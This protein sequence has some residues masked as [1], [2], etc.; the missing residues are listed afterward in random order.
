MIRDL[1][2]PDR[3][4][5]VRTKVGTD[6]WVS[7]RSRS[8]PNLCWDVPIGVDP[9]FVLSLVRKT[10]PMWIPGYDSYSKECV[11]ETYYVDVANQCLNCFKSCLTCTG[12]YYN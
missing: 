8:G 9:V 7:V 10:G 6:R 3:S 1:N 12:L 4:S 2:G 5:L 11:C